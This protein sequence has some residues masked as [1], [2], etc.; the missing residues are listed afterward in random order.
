MLKSLSR[1]LDQAAWIGRFFILGSL[2]LR[3]P[4]SR[5]ALV[6]SRILE[7]IARVL[8]VSASLIFILGFL[9]GFLWSLIWFRALANIGG[10]S[11]LSGFLIEIQLQVLSP[12]LA[13]MVIVVTYMGPMTMDLCLRKWNKEFETLSLMAIPPLHLLAWPRLLGPL[14]AFPLAL[15]I[16]NFFTFLGNYAGAWF[17]VGLRFQDFY[18]DLEEGIK[19]FN[20]LRLLLQ[21]ALMA[22][23][24]SFFALCAAWDMEE[25][26]LFSIPRVTRRAMME[27]FFFA[28]LTGLL[29]TVF[30]A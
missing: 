24:M 10:T 9:S 8:R 7:E 14:I 11:S 2:S 27:A 1:R 23:S 12:F 3:G 29:V 13:A 16:L 5:R 17:F 4:A 26:D 28:S 15:F 30:Y 22:L 21:S 6:W 19:V 25:E 20:L 18:H